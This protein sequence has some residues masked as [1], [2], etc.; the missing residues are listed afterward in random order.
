MR[1]VTYHPLHD[2]M[3][4]LIGCLLEDWIST[5]KFPVNP[6]QKIMKHEDSENH[7]VLGRSWKYTRPPTP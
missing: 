5:E 4:F 3:I 2:S 7:G 6:D 1:E